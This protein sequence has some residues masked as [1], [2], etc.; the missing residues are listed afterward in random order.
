MKKSNVLVT[1]SGGIVSQGII[2]CLKLANKQKKS[3]VN[4]KIFAT[5]ASAKAPGLYRAD[6]GILVPP[7]TAPN[8]LDFITKTCIEKKIMAIFI[9][10]DEELLP[11]TRAR[12]EIESKTGAVV[13]SNP[14]DV[15][16]K[17]GDKWKTYEFLRENGLPCAESS[18]P[19]DK[20]VFIKEQ[21]FP[22]VV[23]PREG[24]GS[25]HFYIVH[26]ARELDNA[27]NAIRNAGWRPL[28]Q[29]YIKGDDSEFT[30][31]IT[32]GYDGKVM[33]SISMKKTLKGG[34]TYRAFIDNFKNIRRSA[35]QVAVKIKAIGAINI[36]AKT[37]NE[38][39]KIFEI[40]A[41]FS[42]TSPLRAVAGINEP[43][44]VF[45]N[46]VLGENI[47]IKEYKKL[48]CM[49][50]WNEVY[51]PYTTYK[52]VEH[53]KKVEHSDAFIPEYF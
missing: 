24:H 47:K 8:Y 25:L 18:L 53:R 28:L 32:I 1:A 16:S 12:Q 6:E 26:N 15:V 36:Q 22:I 49:R 50:Y 7:V 13:L 46:I 44:I 19:Y 37:V 17:A 30:T 40:N 2:K 20:D 51:V 52:K 31:G 34:Q 9:G 35:E 4:Y 3:D 11:L 42:A 48:V 41:R 38:K 45:R 43:D 29:E 23:K 27:E 10:S 5:D 21:G 33:S 39:P 14:V